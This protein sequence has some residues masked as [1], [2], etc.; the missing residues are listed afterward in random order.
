M[1]ILISITP[2][3]SNI[4]AVGLANCIEG[5]NIHLWDINAASPI[6]V[7]DRIKPDIFIGDILCITRGL[8]SC[9]K[10]YKTV[11][12]L[13]DC[14]NNDIRNQKI[15]L[16]NQIKENCRIV[17][18]LPY[19]LYKEIGAEYF[20]T[21]RGFSS[22]SLLTAAD[23]T[24]YNLTEPSDVF[25]SDITIIDDESDQNKK[26]VESVARKYSEKTVKVFGKG[27]KIPQSCG[28]IPEELI[29]LAI[30]SAKVFIQLSSD[31]ID[32]KL[33]GAC[34]L[35]TNI[36]TNKN[37]IIESLFGNDLNQFSSIENLFE[38]IDSLNINNKTDILFDKVSKNHKYLNRAEELYNI[39][40][41]K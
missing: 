39:L 29:P 30:K 21:K 31:T 32:N 17:T 18:Y 28:I 10:K 6:D 12:V 35:K 25:M 27:W 7:F 40:R 13:Y 23:E 24:R 22:S 9:A 33:W 8:V 1:N 36:I 11:L 26:I 41:K 5:A 37:R 16:L 15:E 20:W 38:I 4:H 19:K 3:L 2:N 14:Y 34:L